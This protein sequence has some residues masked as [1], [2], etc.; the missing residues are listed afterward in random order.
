MKKFNNSFKQRKIRKPIANIFFFIW[1]FIL[2]AIIGGLIVS[3]ATPTFKQM[4][5]YQWWWIFVGF[6]TIIW[7]IFFTLWLKN[8]LAYRRSDK[9]SKIKEQQRKLN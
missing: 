4:S 3:L 5:T 1:I 6:L 7:I 9:I 8:L 2:W